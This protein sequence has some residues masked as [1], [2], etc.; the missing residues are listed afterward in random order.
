MLD[1]EGCEGTKIKGYLEVV[2]EAFCQ[3]GWEAIL[4][5]WFRSRKLIFYQTFFLFFK[6]FISINKVIYSDL[7]LLNV[8]ELNGLSCEISRVVHKLA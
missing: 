7:N 4:T 8:V 6:N 5:P 1:F 3:H 2:F